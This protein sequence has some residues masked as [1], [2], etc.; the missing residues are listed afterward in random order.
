MSFRLGTSKKKKKEEEEEKEGI[1]IRR[2]LEEERKKKKEEER[3]KK[4]KAKK[5][6][7]SKYRV[8]SSIKVYFNLENVNSLSLIAP[9][10]ALDLGTG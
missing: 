10:C 6:E 1:I 2:R 7:G 5:E 4:K 8:E 9:P 3:R